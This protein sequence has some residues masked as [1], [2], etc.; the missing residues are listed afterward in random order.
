MHLKDFYEDCNISVYVEIRVND[1]SV[2][3]ATTYSIDDAIT[4]LGN[5]ERHHVIQQAIEQQWQDL[6]EPIEDEET[7]YTR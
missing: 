5:A 7:R 2:F 6:P 3:E 4:E 1:E